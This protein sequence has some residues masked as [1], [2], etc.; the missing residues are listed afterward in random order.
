MIASLRR[1]GFARTCCASLTGSFASLEL[2]HGLRFG[3]SLSL[4]GRLRP[5]SHFLSLLGS[6]DLGA[7]ARHAVS[8]VH[9]HRSN[10][11]NRPDE[12]GW[13]HGPVAMKESHSRSVIQRPCAAVRWTIAV[14]RSPSIALPGTAALQRGSASFRAGL[15]RTRPALE[16]R[17]VR[18][19]SG[20]CCEGGAFEPPT[21]Y[22][23]LTV[24]KGPLAAIRPRTR[25]LPPP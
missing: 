23:R 7:D 22:L 4:V 12:R 17:K 14:R 21:V 9:A 5:L 25:T 24:C 1:R 2:R 6:C 10:P 11:A 3:R 13:L 15:R 16:A 20:I 8:R 18:G 19:E